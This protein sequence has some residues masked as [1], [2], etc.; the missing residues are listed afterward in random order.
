MSEGS[1]SGWQIDFIRRLFFYEMVVSNFESEDLQY[2][3]NSNPEMSDIEDFSEWLE[4][5]DQELQ[6]KLMEWLN[7][8]GFGIEEYNQLYKPTKKE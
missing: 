1:F 2:F 8:R 7:D 5:E 4:D 6:E 3:L